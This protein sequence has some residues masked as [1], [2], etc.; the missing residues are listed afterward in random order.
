ML[1]SVG[2]G[3]AQCHA[4]CIENCA[5]IAYNRLMMPTSVDRRLLTNEQKMQLRH[6]LTLIEEKLQD[7]S[8]LMR[9]CYG[10]D[11]QAAIRADETAAALQRLK[12]ELER[13]Q[14]KQ[15]AAAG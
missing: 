7:I 12:W 1:W 11:S 4:T 15:H 10:D 9:V 6:D 2:T 14:Q 5:Q 8:I 3:T 13:M